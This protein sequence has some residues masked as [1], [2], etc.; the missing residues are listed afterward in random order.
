LAGARYRVA[1]PAETDVL[2]RLL[3]SAG[4]YRGRGD[5]PESGPFLARMVVTPALAG[6]AAILDYETTTDRDGLRHVEH[7]VLL[8]GADGRLELHVA[9]LD[10]P[11]M[12]RFTQQTPGQFTAYEGPLLARIVLT[13]PRP[14]L[15]SYAWWW[16]RDDREPREQYRADL[17]R[18][19]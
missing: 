16:S 10:L 14:G 19:D 8:L 12:V 2:H 7:S 3:R 17:R 1:V 13:L 11:G 9:S 18:T 15:L 4:V 6:R 5:G